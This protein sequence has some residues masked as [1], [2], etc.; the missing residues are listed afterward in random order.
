MVRRRKRTK[1]KKYSLVPK[2]VPV[3][4]KRAMARSPIQIRGSERKGA[5]KKKRRREDMA[6]AHKTGD[7]EE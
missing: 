3:R 6:V 1:G 4:G 2:R 5:A 7:T